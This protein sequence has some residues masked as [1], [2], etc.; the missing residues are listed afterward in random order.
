MNYC[1]TY[2]QKIISSSIAQFGTSAPLFAMQCYRLAQ[3]EI[4]VSNIKHLL[5]P[6]KLSNGIYQL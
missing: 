3:H 1:P 5:M 4:Y 2:A 6:T